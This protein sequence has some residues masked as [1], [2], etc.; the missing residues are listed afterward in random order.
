MA[1]KRKIRV[2]IV[3]DSASVRQAL[4]AVLREDP[5]IEVIG[6]APDPF[7]AARRIR[8]EIP[9]VIL[10]D[11]EMPRMDGITFLRRLMAQH[12]LPVVICSSHVEE[13]SD[14]LIQALAAGAM[15][16]ILKPRFGAA[17]FLEESGILIRDAVKA[18]AAA[19]LDPRA[20]RLIGAG[21][22]EPEKKLSADAMLPPPD[23]T[24]KTRVG[25]KVVC[26]GASTG[27]PEA[28]CEALAALPAD[29][30]GII[31]VQHMPEHF[32][33]GFARRMDSLCTISVK[34]AKDGDAVRRGCVLIAP[35]NYHIMLEGGDGK[36]SVAVRPGP[37]V[38]RHR[39]S[40]DVLFRSAAQVA[41]PNAIGV[42]MTGMGDDGAHGLYEMKKAGA[43][44]IAQNEATSTVFG[45]PKEAIALGGVDLVLP[46]GEIAGG[47]LHAAAR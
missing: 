31:V 33:A 25:E 23:Y 29:A 4:A 42:I 15:D 36:Y 19:R 10:L 12:P 47:I 9:D 14:A 26:I 45:M 16:V 28:L 32:T 20:G 30:P 35:G 27:G 40:A 8:N 37:L 17:E 22:Y 11:I 13:G 38:S 7:A 3:D 41:G 43:F 21:L 2:L 34:E 1:V 18:A 46:L 6:C 44:T 24:M 5:G 39:P